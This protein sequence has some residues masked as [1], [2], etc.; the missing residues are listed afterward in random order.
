MYSPG[1]WEFNWCRA[2]IE[3]FDQHA[4]ESVNQD[5]DYELFR[6]W[7]LLWTNTQNH[8]ARF[9]DIW[10]LGFPL[11]PPSP[12]L[13]PKCASLLFREFFFYLAEYEA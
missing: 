11:L 2:Q 5:V 9:P 4:V 12:H 7:E 8:R 6:G 1:I 10:I 13:H 3:G